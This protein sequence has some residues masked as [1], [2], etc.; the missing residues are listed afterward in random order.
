MMSAP[1]DPRTAEPRRA[2]EMLTLKNARAAPQER[3]RADRNDEQALCEI[4]DID[5]KLMELRQQ[6]S[7]GSQ[8]ESL[9]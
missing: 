3:L 5:A 4:E 1:L 8:S 9:R 2:E 7:G 6:Q